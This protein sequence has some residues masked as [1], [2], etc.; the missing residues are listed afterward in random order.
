LK[1]GNNKD[2]ARHPKSLQKN[3]DSFNES[4]ISKVEKIHPRTQPQP[5]DKT[6]RKLKARRLE[7]E[8][9]NLSSDSFDERFD[10]QSSSESQYII[11]DDG[12]GK[13]S[14]RSTG[15]QRRQR[16][17]SSIGITKKIVKVMNKQYIDEIKRKSVF[18][19]TF[20]YEKF[21]SIIKREL[22][23]FF[24]DPSELVQNSNGQINRKRGGKKK[25]LSQ[26]AYEFGNG[27][28]DIKFDGQIGAR[29]IL[30]LK[31]SKGR[32][33]QS[34]IN[35][36]NHFW[37]LISKTFLNKFL[38]EDAKRGLEMFLQD[39]QKE[40]ELFKNNNNQKMINKVEPLF[41]EK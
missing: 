24:L 3:D 19:E 9:A 33:P 18:T 32:I 34:S 16:Y 23:E 4:S 38:L 15:R 17:N 13:S 39:S 28:F 40:R 36:A 8:S 22:K 27:F 5:T 12:A 41:N 10:Q 31:D 14:K 30:N 7:K 1:A 21:I 11:Q 26:G 6:F 35:K 37:W 25:T 2:A 20:I 29:N